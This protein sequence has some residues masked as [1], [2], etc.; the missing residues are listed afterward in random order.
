MT[1]EEK[2]KAKAE[3]KAAKEAEKLA[4]AKAEETAKLEAEA[5]AKAEA[6]V[7]AAEETRAT[8]ADQAKAKTA[9]E[10]KEA[11]AV[12][13]EAEK[14]GV[15]K[16][17]VG[18]AGY[19][20]KDKT[21]EKTAR[22]K[23]RHDKLAAERLKN[24]VAK[25]KLKAK[26]KPIEKRKALFVGRFKAIRSRVRAS[27]YTNATVEAWTEEFNLIINNPRQWIKVTKNGTVPYSP[28]NKR[29]KTA[30]ELLDGMNL[31]DESE[32]SRDPVE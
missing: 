31:D 18:M 10:T 17:K 1:N 22:E 30:K 15:K 21:P 24:R 28:G 14:L 11:A 12:E 16:S 3:A 25:A 5:K 6:E 32:D 7:T 23:A 2:Q 9:G 26:M 27:T 20:I 4:K 13:E 19:N 8:L 29:K